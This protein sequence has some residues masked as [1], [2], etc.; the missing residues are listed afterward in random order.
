MSKARVE[1]DFDTMIALSIDPEKSRRYYESSKPECEGTCT[2]C[3]KMCPARTMKRIL[4]GETYRSANYIKSPIIKGLSVN[5]GSQTAPLV[6]I[7]S[8]RQTN[9]REA[10][11]LF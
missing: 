11:I 3:G 10:P 7:S 9:N 4:A 5:E 6:C 2:M 8:Y 1:V